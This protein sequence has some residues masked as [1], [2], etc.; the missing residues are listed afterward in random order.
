MAHVHI[1]YTMSDDIEIEAFSSKEKALR[2]LDYYIE[3]CKKQENTN[4]I[5]G[6]ESF[7]IV[8][9]D[10]DSQ[11]VFSCEYMRKVIR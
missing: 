5:G 9:D 6:G 10:E 11:Q 4:L 1:L 3:E 2:K 7:I 8:T